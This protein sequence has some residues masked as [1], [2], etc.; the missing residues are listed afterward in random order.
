MGVS[1]LVNT[2]AGIS[3]AASIAFSGTLAA[4]ARSVPPSRMSAPAKPDAVFR[5]A[6]TRTAVG[7]KGIA[8]L[9]RRAPVL[10][11]RWF[12]GSAR[13]VRFLGSTLVSIDYEDGHVA[14]RLLARVG[15]PA[16]VSTWEVLR[17]EV[18]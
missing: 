3:F 17:D 5:A 10:G 8:R 15:D 2:L 7:H 4:A 6:V 1:R 12:V 13:D 16:D 11:G 14:G 9:T 18:R